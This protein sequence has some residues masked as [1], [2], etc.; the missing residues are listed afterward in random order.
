MVNYDEIKH[1]ANIT[2]NSEGIIIDELHRTLPFLTKF[3]YTKIIG[4]RAKQ[5]DSG[6]EPFISVG[7]SVSEGDTL[8]IVCLLYTSPSPRDS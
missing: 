2:R 7:S 3:E 8:L 4:Q 6:A 5:I 1:Y